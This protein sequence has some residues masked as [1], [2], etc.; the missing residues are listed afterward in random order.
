MT[1]VR[2]PIQKRDASDRAG[3]QG[4]DPAHEQPRHRAVRTWW[5]A[6]NLSFYFGAIFLLAFGTWKIFE[7]STAEA[8]L[9]LGIAASAMC[10]SIFALRH[11]A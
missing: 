8:C 4:L 6:D 9:C 5:Q 10:V 2:V 1:A 3:L 11:V 7:G